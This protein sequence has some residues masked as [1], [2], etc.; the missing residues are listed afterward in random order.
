MIFLAKSKWSQAVHAGKG[1]KVPRTQPTVQP[2]YQTSVFSFNSLEEVDQA[3]SGEEGAFIYSRY[4]NPTVHALEQALAALESACSGIV[5]SSGMASITATLLSFC[6][7]GDHIVAAEDLYGGT[8]ALVERELSRFGISTSFVDA[9]LPDKV[10]AAMRPNT[11]AIF[12]ETISNPLMRLVDF[13]ALAVLKRAYKLKLI[14]D[15]TFA[16]PMLC[17]P[18]ELGADLVV[19]S[20]TK[21]I[22]GHSDV[23]AGAVV[24]SVDDI[25]RIKPLQIQLGATASPFDAW[26]VMRSIGTL[27]LRMRQHTE[28]A[29]ILANFLTEQTGVLRVHYPGLPGHPQHALAQRQLCGFGGMLSFVVEGGSYGAEQLVKAL[30]M[31]DFVPSLAGV[32][33]T[34]SHPAKTSHRALTSLARARLGIDDGMIRVSVGLEDPVD[35]CADFAQALRYNA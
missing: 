5:T 19:E 34:I 8:H 3:F 26:L 11:K 2:I 18:M 35:I 15:N 27:P 31:V 24:G 28:S 17:R 20:L 12:V 30:S 25:E 10:E 33:T 9:T 14:V 7:A 29:L 23:T 32:A 21:Y 13:S 22:N 16:S 6:S 4:G 1:H